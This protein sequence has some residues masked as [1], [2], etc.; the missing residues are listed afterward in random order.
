MSKATISKRKL[1]IRV[2]Q[3]IILGMLLVPLVSFF[4]G[5]DG[6]NWDG[7]Y[8]GGSFAIRGYPYRYINVQYIGSSVYHVKYYYINFIADGLILSI[9]SPFILEPLRYISKQ[10]NLRED[11]AKYYQQKNY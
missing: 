3:W 6:G 11:A 1:G 10:I 4:E 7:V 5:G 2:I 9:I 8:G